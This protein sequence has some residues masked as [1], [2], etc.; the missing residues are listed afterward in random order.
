MAMRGDVRAKA[1][2]WRLLLQD[3]ESDPAAAHQR[4]A[5]LRT[6]VEQ[7]NAAAADAHVCCAA[8]FLRCCLRAKKYE[9]PKAL[10]LAI[11]YDAYRRRCSW[12]NGSISVSELRPE[13]ES[14][15]NLVL[16]KSDAH[17]QVVIT[18]TMSRLNLSLPGA[19]VERYQRAGY[20]LIHRA[21]HERPA[22]QLDGL[23]LLLDFR[24][25]GWSQF[26]EMR[27]ADFRRGVAMLQDA[28]PARLSVVYVVHQPRWLSL[29]FALIRPFLSADSL[30]K[31]FHLFGDDLDGLHA[32]LPAERIPQQLQLGGTAT[33]DW[34]AQL[35][36]W[37]TEEGAAFEPLSL[38][39]ATGPD[40]APS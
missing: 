32:H 21:L 20:Y 27:L 14:G 38:L 6:L 36:A 13:L 10:R 9:L 35:G 28:F 11:N 37:A 2:A 18:Q 34:S 16:P 15:F 23:A 4:V 40:E 19:S 25:W 1:D 3:V 30:E 17:G 24:G 39:C 22:A 5:E 8:P 7:H 31:K 26:R 12:P 29:L 33:L